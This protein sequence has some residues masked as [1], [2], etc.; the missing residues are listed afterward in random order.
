MRDAVLI[1]RFTRGFPRA[2]VRAAAVAAVAALLVSAPA[3]ARRPQNPVLIQVTRNSVG[4]IER[5]QIRSEQGDTIVFVSDGDVLSSGT[6][7]GHRE[8]YL[9]DALTGVITRITNT[10]DGESYS[11]A[12]ETDSQHSPRPRFVVFTSTGDLDPS[13]GNGDHN[14]EL[15]VWLRETGEY[16]QLTDTQPPI[17]NDQAYASDNGKCI[18]FRS[19]GDF[20]NNDG[21]DDKNPGRGFDNADGSFEIF[22]LDFTENDLSAAVVTQVSNGPAGT[23]SS[24]PSVG[25]FW[26]TRQCRSTSYQSDYDQI[27]NGSTGIH[28]YNYTRTSG[29]IEQSSIPGDG[30][31]VN[32]AMSA[33]SNFARGPF[34]IYETDMEMIP[35]NPPGSVEIM[36]FRYFRPELI[37]FTLDVSADKTLQSARPSISDGGAIVAFESKGEL[38]DS[39]RRIR[40]G[41]NPPFNA[42]GNVEIFRAKAIRRIWQITRSE[43]CEN[44]HATMRDTG[45]ALAFRSTC[46]LV[47]GGNPSG[48]PQ[49]FHYFEVHQSDPLF[50][51]AGCKVEDGCCNEAN[52]C[53]EL[54]Y[55][56]KIKVPKSKL[57]PKWADEG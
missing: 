30:K 2:S 42:D 32:P 10:T 23:T 11:A 37:Q 46:D 35:Q 55:S 19:N 41:S 6:E 3:L 16:L 24:Q 52:G 57:R 40:Y 1:T 31:N 29:R 45:R 18:V 21:S 53:Y 50:S 13:V 38:I 49:V 34:V 36:R 25:G 5:P 39:S 27:G 28:I 15:F 9:Y 56:R 7:T 51:A 47:P 20:D 8:V 12:R 14:P 48:V 26:Y 22:N 43:G 54:I 17:A 4:E 44:T 33:A